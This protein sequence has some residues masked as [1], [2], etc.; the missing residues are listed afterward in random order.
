[1]AVSTL[2]DLLADTVQRFVSTKVARQRLGLTSHQLCRLVK[3]GAVTTRRLPGLRLMIL[4]SDIS[5]LERD[6]LHPAIS[7]GEA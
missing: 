5:R 1:M 6:S 3:V 2:V 4:E 7:C